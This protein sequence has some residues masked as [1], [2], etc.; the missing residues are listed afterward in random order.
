[1]SETQ[2]E[3]LLEWQSLDSHPH[4][5]SP[6]W[7][8]SGGVVLVGLASYGLFDGSWTTALLA[9]MLAGVYFI[10]RRIEARKVNVQITGMGINTD[11]VFSSWNQCKDFW[12]LMP[13]PRE[14]T[15]KSLI[16]QIPELH[17]SRRGPFKPETTLFL[18]EIDP[19]IVRETLLQY[20]PERPG[21]EERVLDSLARILKL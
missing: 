9:I 10:M 4:E 14:Y 12:I 15:K 7:Y 8:I 19:A 18:N 13:Q 6:R 17:I 21:M 20:L 1:M 11:S 3:I 16:R 2:T 5:R